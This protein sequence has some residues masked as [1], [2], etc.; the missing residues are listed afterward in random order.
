[1][2]EQFK[3]VVAELDLWRDQELV[4]PVW[5][6]DDDATV[7][8]PALDRLVALSA[9]FGAPLHLAVIPEPATEALAARLRRAPLVSVLPHG[10]QHR[11]HA[12]AD[13]K[14]AEFGPHRPVAEMLAEIAAG[15]R[16][17]SELFGAQA[18]ARLHPAVEPDCAGTCRR[19]AASRHARAFDVWSAQ[20]QVSQPK[21]SCRSTRISTR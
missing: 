17:V 5:W 8:S 12:P 3:T 20:G 19:A 18:L 15:W 9:R 2:I 4:L 11:N 16:L 1:M 10:W 14:K 7:P 21:A 13:Q 6:R